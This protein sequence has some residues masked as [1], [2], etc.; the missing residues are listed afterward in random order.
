LS[1]DGTASIRGNGPTFVPLSGIIEVHKLDIGFGYW[2]WILDLDIGFGYW[3]W[4]LDLDK[5]V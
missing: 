1:K 3:I 5:E 2:I 4:I